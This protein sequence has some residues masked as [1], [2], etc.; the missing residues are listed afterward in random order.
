M[1]MERGGAQTGWYRVQGQSQ[2]VRDRAL[3]RTERDRQECF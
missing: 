2:G 1:G 3:S